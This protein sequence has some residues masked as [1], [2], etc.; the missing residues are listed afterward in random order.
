MRCLGLGFSVGLL[1]PFHMSSNR[2]AQDENSFAE[3]GKQTE[4][5][6]VFSS[7]SLT[8]LVGL[9]GLLGT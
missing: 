4:L 5:A 6:L 3:A 9:W 8:L 7:G 2:R 1:E